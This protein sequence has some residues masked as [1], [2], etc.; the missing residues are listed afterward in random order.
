MAAWNEGW[1]LQRRQL[2]SGYTVFLV[3]GGPLLQSIIFQP[4]AFSWEETTSFERLLLET[5]F[6]GGLAK[7]MG[8]SVMI[9]WCT[10]HTATALQ[11]LLWG[12]LSQGW[13]VASV[14]LKRGALLQCG[15]SKA[16]VCR[17]DGFTKG[18]LL[19]LED[20]SYLLLLWPF[21]IADS[22]TIYAAFT[23]F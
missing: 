1:S 20:C 17:D 8:W 7:L 9:R 15:L 23:G 19:P 13:S 14:A 18:Q 6:Y 22:R 2:G 11:I 21:H 4:E 16:V 12:G 5:N 3:R 10:V